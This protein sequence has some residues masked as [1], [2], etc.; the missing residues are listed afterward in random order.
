MKETDVYNTQTPANED[1]C[2][3]ESLL[4]TSW[5]M[6][7]VKGERFHI[8]RRE[9]EQK[10]RI[11]RLQ[12]RRR[13]QDMQSLF[14]LEL[15]NIVRPAFL[16]KVWWGRSHCIRRGKRSDAD[17]RADAGT[18][19]LP[20]L[21]SSQQEAPE[22]E[23]DGEENEGKGDDHNEAHRRPDAKACAGETEDVSC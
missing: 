4:F 5:L 13:K 22:T 19:F 16:R 9:G 14:V 1:Y 15:S 20:P 18:R 11:C 17:P 8:R 3:T 21:R 12:N 2:F 6:I 10:P 23:Q 7:T